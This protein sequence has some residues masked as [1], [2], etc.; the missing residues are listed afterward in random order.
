M[1]I[2]RGELKKIIAEETHN[3]LEEGFL[4]SVMGFF[5]KMS[6]QDKKLVKQL[7]AATGEFMDSDAFQGLY[8]TD[9]HIPYGDWDER[10]AEVALEDVQAAWQGFQAIRQA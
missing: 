1:K 9:W 2:T 6:N 7:Y 4:D 5:G 3:V 8:D 10:D